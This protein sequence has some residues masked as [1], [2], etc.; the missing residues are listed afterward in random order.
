MHR[1][2]LAPEQCRADLLTLTGGEAHHA[3]KVLRVQPG[4]RVI[5]LN[6][7]GCEFLCEVVAGRRDEAT[8]SVLEERSIPPLPYQ[9]TLAQALPKGKLFESI[10]QKATE[11]GAFEIVPLL[12]E[13]VVAH[14]GDTDRAHKLQK[15]QAVAVEAIKQCGSAWLPKIVA[16]MTPQQLV[17]RAAE[18][19][20][21]VVGSLEPDAEHPRDSFKLFL[22][23]R[24]R[25]PRS[26]C[27]WIGPEGDFTTE[28]LALIK[29]SGARPITLG[30]LVLRTET[31]AL[32]CLSILNYEFTFTQRD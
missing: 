2:F 31:A 13:R 1:C 29:S 9:I 6:G 5:V 15:W 32:Y 23:E 28:E 12:T 24:G 18:F 7:A 14:L 27:V 20:L 22:S 4:D 30:S 16:P 3:L 19:E 10:V 26:A 8:L 21:A 25:V 11:L 17:K